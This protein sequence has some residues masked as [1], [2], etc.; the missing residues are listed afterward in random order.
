MFAGRRV[1]LGSALVAAV[2]CIQFLSAGANPPTVGLIQNDPGTFDGYTLFSPSRYNATYLVDN[3]G[4]EVHTWPATAAP[5]VNYLQPDGTLLRAI[6]LGPNPFFTGGGATGRVERVAWDGTILWQFDYTTPDDV[7]HHDIEELPNGNVLMIA[8]DS[9]TTAEAIA[10]GRSPSL[11]ASGELQPDYIIEVQPTGPTTGSIVWEW[12]VWDHLVQDIDNT[13]ANFGVVADHPELADINYVDP[14]ITPNGEADWMHSNAIDYNPELDQIMLSVRH[15][16][17]LWIIDHTTTTAEA[18]GHTGGDSGKGGDLLYRWGNPEAYGAGDASDRVFYLQHDTQW[19]KPGLPGAGNI[20]V[21]NNGNGRPGDDYSSVDEF[22]P[23][24]DVDG[25]Y[26]YTSGQPYG[27][28]GLT[29]TYVAPDPPTFY[30][31]FISGAVRLPNG[32]TLID[33]GVF[34][35]LF[36]VTSAGDILWT[37]VNPVQVS[38]PVAQGSF[39]VNLGN[40]VFRAYK[41]PPNYSG[42]AGQDLTPGLPLEITDTDSDGLANLDEVKLYG[43]NPNS[44]DTDGDTLTDGQEVTGV[45]SPKGALGTFF[46]NP[47]LPDT[48]GDGCPDN[49]ELG[50]NVKLGGL[51]N[52]TSEWDY[53]NPTHDKI[54]RVDDILVVLHQY[55]Q[56]KFLPAPPNPPGTPNPAYREDTD[57]SAG[58]PHVWNLGPPDGIV[59]L[60]DILS[61]V[62][63]YFHDCH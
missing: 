14:A 62:K 63:Q 48:D 49:R 43:T 41:Y 7:I 11:L 30:S 59:R 18:A 13:K 31:A 54:N 22:V 42:L 56:D 19:V 23:P 33:D 15:F 61:I 9:K 24:V 12:H 4:R 38:G 58:G 16:N 46:P 25:Q 10:A 20:M 55:F 27:P 8:W 6:T 37:Y 57:R 32:N 45:S 5:L 26:A 17:E 51:R 50:T 40:I 39:P 28:S 60:D 36:E 47:L 52:P 29:W 35:R 3:Q 53:F 1:F 2:Y 21:F 34:G 44:S